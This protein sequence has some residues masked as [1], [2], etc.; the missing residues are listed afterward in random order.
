M[1]HLAAVL[2]ALL[3][4]VASL[5]APPSYENFEKA[6]VAI[7]RRD[8]ATSAEIRR[9]LREHQPFFVIVPGILGSKL[10]DG[11]KVIWGSVEARDFFRKHPDRLSYPEHK[12]KADVLLSFEIARK[13][14]LPVYGPLI[15]ATAALD[16]S[17]IPHH[18]VFPYDWRQ[19]VVDSAAQLDQFLR[20]PKL[21]QS[22]GGRDVVII[23]HS[24]G[25]LVTT[26]WYHQYYA[27]HPEHYSFPIANFLLLGVPHRGAPSSLLAIAT[28]YQPGSHP[29]YFENQV[30][31]FLF[32]ELNRAAVTFPGL[33]DL[34]PDAFKSVYETGGGD[35]EIFSAGSWLRYDWARKARDA[36]RAGADVFYPT[37]IQPMLDRASE[38]HRLITD[39]GTL[40]VAKTYFF[41][42]KSHDTVTG[43]L[44]E[45]EKNNV[46]ALRPQWERDGDERVPSYSAVPGNLA[47]EHPDH[48]IALQS[49]HGALPNDPSF[50]AWVRDYRWSQ[51]ASTNL[52]FIE[53]AKQKPFIVDEMRKAGAV[54][55]LPSSMSSL[56]TAE[57]RAT[58]E[59]NLAVTPSIDSANDAYSAA[60]QAPNA[61]HR[62]ELYATAA[63][64]GGTENKAKQVE[65][66]LGVALL[67]SDQPAEAIAHF[68][69]ASEEVPVL[70]GESR[71]DYLAKVH[72]N[73]AV[74]YE[75]SGQYANAESEYRKAIAL[76]GYP[77]AR[78]NLA[79]LQENLRK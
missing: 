13:V 26:S 47:A 65:F 18:T 75:R 56:S 20:D 41:Y 7:D 45:R 64:L 79:V 61:P 5:A 63:A 55:P 72:A 44:M 33:F 57:A 70:S 32:R 48:V 16:V 8:P 14:S 42:S 49:T 29:S 34:L 25:G 62:A 71:T 12:L 36:R 53:L 40:P 59:F 21:A 43:I 1:K 38:L 6:L 74:A 37:Y 4:A 54:L 77:Q 30:Y 69:R 11:N 27:P 24:M 60:K 51:I 10:S 28:G 2:C 46:Y 76:N 58:A 17:S 3:V 9:I 15:D 52:R 78:K 35:V 39:K 67:N 50:R 66:N 19:N 73:L 31:S 22:I 68:V 23:A